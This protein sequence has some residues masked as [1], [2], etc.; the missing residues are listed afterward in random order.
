MKLMVEQQCGLKV[1]VDQQEWYTVDQSVVRKWRVVVGRTRA[2]KIGG[3]MEGGAWSN[4]AALEVTQM[5]MP[6]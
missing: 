5:K 3:Q 4:Y 2:V 6:A 1:V